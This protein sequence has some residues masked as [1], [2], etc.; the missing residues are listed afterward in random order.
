VALD[1]AAGALLVATASACY[2]FAYRDASSDAG[3]AAQPGVGDAAGGA[4]VTD[5]LYCGG[6]RLIGAT[7]VLYRCVAD[8][9]AALEKKCASGCEPDAG[10]GA[11][12]NPPVSP[13]KAGGAYCGG[14]KLDGDPRVLY[15]CAA[16]GAHAVLESC[17]NGCRVMAAGVDDA[18]VP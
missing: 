7:D 17:A 10:N 2:D 1:A 12:C 3:D 6:D 18:C 4:C 9:G 13:C 14:D 16:G 11:R 8:G 5:G 15:R